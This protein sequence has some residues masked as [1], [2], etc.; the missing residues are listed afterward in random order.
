MD[1]K[2]FAS[3]VIVLIA[4][5]VIAAGVGI[6]YYTRST[7]K[8]HN[9]VSQNTTTTAQL[10]STSSVSQA[11]STSNVTSS[12][13][14]TPISLSKSFF[15]VTICRADVETPESGSLNSNAAPAATGTVLMFCGQSTGTIYGMV[16]D[17][18]D[19]G[20]GEVINGDLY[21]LKSSN[22][23]QPTN[24]Y[25]AVLNQIWLYKGST[26]VKLIYTSPSNQTSSIFGIL[27][28]PDESLIALVE[29][30]GGLEIIDSQGNTI[31]SFTGSEK[32][33]LAAF[34]QYCN[35]SDCDSPPIGW[36]KDSL[37]VEM[38][39][40][41][42][43]TTYGRINLADWSV[44]SYFPSYTSSD[45]EHDALNYDTG[46]LAVSNLPLL[47][48]TGSSSELADFLNSTTTIALLIDDLI[49]GATQTIATVPTLNASILGYGFAPR[50][51]DDNTV[52]YY[53][54]SGITA[55]ATVQ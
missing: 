44:K 32:V 40:E 43:G 17:P 15:D 20:P 14:V 27:V 19:F 7:P 4:A 2:G 35:D 18:N 39:S 55:T 29:V 53:L 25:Q 16:S 30:G 49:T 23:V 5:I 48:S 51:I 6:F 50:W 45:Q 21:I 1:K 38:S 13:E 24:Q 8:S 9:P 31:K 33:N 46:E 28:S 10:E 54:A 42:N 26:P 3:L 37:W 11:T 41:G 36:G 47:A 12:P 52:S 34:P 22:P